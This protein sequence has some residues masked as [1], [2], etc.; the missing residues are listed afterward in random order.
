MFSFMGEFKTNGHCL[1]FEI[2]GVIFFST[3]LNL[4]TWVIGSLSEFFNA[5]VDKSFEM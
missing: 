3:R 2:G 4:W 5:D 1:I